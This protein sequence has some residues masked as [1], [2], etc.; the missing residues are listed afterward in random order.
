MDGG[1]IA[2]CVIMVLITIAFTIGV[3]IYPARKK[4]QIREQ[5]NGLASNTLEMSVAEF[6]K[7]RNYRTGRYK[8]SL[9]HNFT[10]VYILFN[11]TKNMYYI[12]QATQILNR[13]NGHFTGKRNGDVYADYKYGDEF[14][15]KMIQLD[16]SGYCS[17]NELER[18]TIM[19]YDAFAHGY[20]KTRGN[21]QGLIK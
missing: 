11:K 1:I 17:L 20:N 9:G 19:T 7:M 13:V 10:G 18:N 14:T 3:Y 16:K 5:I 12:G 4:E 2:I 6:F 21:R 15:I 8:Y